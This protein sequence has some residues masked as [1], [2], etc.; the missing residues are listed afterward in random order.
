MV[1][2]DWSDGA[3]L[4]ASSSSSDNFTGNDPPITPARKTVLQEPPSAL[5]RKMLLVDLAPQRPVHFGIAERKP[6]EEDIQHHAVARH[7]RSLQ[8]RLAPRPWRLRATQQ[9]GG[10]QREHENATQKR[11]HATRKGKGKNRES[12]RA[13]R[14]LAPRRGVKGDCG[15]GIGDSGQE[16]S[17]QSAIGGVSPE[18][19]TPFRDKA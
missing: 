9:Q 16:P 11:Q 14:V 12:N 15:S 17:I 7:L 1:S 19:I 5:G 2:L 18:S 8:R 3:G 10:S 13:G 6:H 4:S